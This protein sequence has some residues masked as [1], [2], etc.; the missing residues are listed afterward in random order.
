MYAAFTCKG[1]I[2]RKS[3]D[4]QLPV[5]HTAHFLRWKGTDPRNLPT[6]PLVGLSL[7][8]PLRRAAISS[9]LPSNHYPRTLTEGPSSPQDSPPEDGLFSE[10]PRLAGFASSLSLSGHPLG[11]P[12]ASAAPPA[13]TFCR[14]CNFPSLWRSETLVGFIICPAN[15]RYQPWFSKRFC[16]GDHFQSVLRT[17]FSVVRTGE[18]RLGRPAEN[19]EAAAF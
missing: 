2:Y 17:H 10:F 7:Q 1:S 18:L 9:E 6:P 15:P 16:C 19:A 13:P 14:P 5:L 4:L 8:P 3:L 11:Q 12:R